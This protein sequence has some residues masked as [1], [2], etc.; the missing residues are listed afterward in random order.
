M[1]KAKNTSANMAMFNRNTASID[2]LRKRKE[3]KSLSVL[4]RQRPQVFNE[5]CN[6]EMRKLSVRD[7][8]KELNKCFH[9]GSRGQRKIATIVARESGMLPMTEKEVL[10]LT[11]FHNKSSLEHNVT[12]RPNVSHVTRMSASGFSLSP[13]VPEKLEGGVGNEYQT[14]P[15][16]QNDS[17]QAQAN[18]SG[19]L[20][21]N[22]A[23]VIDS[24]TGALSL[25]FGQP[26]AQQQEIVVVEGQERKKRSNVAAWVIG[27]I[28]VVAAIGTIVYFARRKK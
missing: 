8:L 6:T 24:A 22:I 15:N 18:N 4:V 19:A 1:A 28:L 5:L 9:S 7:R 12:A 27:S 23:N 14:L 21:N 10:N 3:V 13:W 16:S 25:F 2:N 11:D 26:P 20:L 17:E